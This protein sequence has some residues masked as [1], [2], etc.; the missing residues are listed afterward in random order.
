MAVSPRIFVSYRREDASGHSGRLYDSLKERFPGLVFRDVD[1]LEPGDDFVARIEELLDSTEVLIAV[2]GRGWATDET[3]HRRIDEPDDWLRLEV[4]AGLRRDIRVIPVLVGGAKMPQ[5]EELPDDLKAL[6][7]RNSLDLNDL[8]WDS[9]REKLFMTI[10]RVL[11]PSAT[12]EPPA[13]I[14][15]PTPPLPTAVLPLAVVGAALLAVGLFMRWDAGRHSFLQNNFGGALPHG[16][17]FTALA[18]VGIVVAAVLGA[19]LARSAGTRAVGVG[20]LF[21]AGLAGVV[22]Y[23]RVLQA[24]HDQSPGVRIGVLLA[25]AGGVLVLAA[26]FLALQATL[27]RESDRNPS[28]AIF[29]IVGA[30]VMITATA[31]DFKGDGTDPRY[32]AAK[33]ARSFGEAFDPVMTSLLIGLIAALLFGRSRH[34][35]LSAA[36]I[37][38]GALA[39]LLWFRYLA[40]PVLEE[41]WAGSF[42]PGGLVGLAGALLVVVGGLLGLR[43]SREPNVVA[44]PAAT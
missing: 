22:K 10:E 40:V 31:I 44:V 8:A 18:P 14:R 33:L 13:P 17:V 6:A 26:A 11:G 32:P 34:A 5:A 36:L 9:G 29:G 37:T 7:H 41:R 30:V 19:V 24:G 23:L 12:P 25:I 4:G 3:G 1:S 20:V 27:T 35:E 42:A 28:A 43:G 38:L 16:G 2:I 21:G 15:E 39:A